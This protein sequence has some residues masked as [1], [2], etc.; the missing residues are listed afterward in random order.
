M[1]LSGDLPGALD[2]VERAVRVGMPAGELALF[3]AW[4]AVLSGE[5][6]ESQRLPNASVPL[7][8]VIFEA[9]L[10]V[11]EFAAFESLY[12]LLA[13]TEL[14]RREQ[15]ELMATAY[16]RR[17]HLPQAAQEWMAVCSQAPDAR[18]LTGLALVAELHGQPQDAVVFAHEALAI[19]PGNTTAR[20]VADRCSL[21]AAA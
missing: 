11:E 4:L 15:R 9:L 6:P 8:H 16:L 20:A 17:G 21:A 14:P 18:A 5:A 2:A 3:T 13:R 7:L 1:I 12:P 19:E 10:R